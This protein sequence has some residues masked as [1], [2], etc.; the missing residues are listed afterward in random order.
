M[1]PSKISDAE[2]QRHEET[3]RHLYIDE[4]LTLDMLMNEM[5]SLH[6]FSAT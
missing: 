4:K 1:A 3:I 6:G 5:S 2:W